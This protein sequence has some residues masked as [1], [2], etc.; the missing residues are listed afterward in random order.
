V[1]VK[2]L[3]V[4][5]IAAQPFIP[6]ARAQ[7]EPQFAAIAG[8]G[9]GLTSSDTAACRALLRLPSGDILIS[10]LFERAG[11][12][13]SANLAT[14]HPSTDTFDPISPSPNAS[15]RCL[16]RT[17]DG[18]IIAG[19]RFTAIGGVAANYIAAFDPATGLW[20]PLGSG[21]SG[22]VNAIAV[23]PSGDIV[24]GGEFF[25]A[26]GQTVRSVARYN[27]ASGAWAPLGTGVSGYVHSLL[28]LPS[29]DVLVGGDFTRVGSL[30]IAALA[31]YSFTT[32][33]W[34][35]MGAV[36][37]RSGQAQVLT[38]VALR[39]NQVLVGGW[40]SSI[41]GVPA[42]NVAVFD[43]ELGA[44]T[45]AGVGTD[46]IVFSAVEMQNGD[47]IVGGAFHAFGSDLVSC[48]A[49]YSPATQSW[50]TMGPGLNSSVRALAEGPDGGV[51]A[52]GDFSYSS[53]SRASRVA[54]YNPQTSEWAPL[55]G[56]PNDYVATVA[57][58]SGAVVIGGEFTH[59]MGLQ[60]NHVAKL[61]PLTGLW[62]SL[63]LGVNDTVNSVVRLP[64]GELA[65]GGYFTTAGPI[66]AA[67]IAI[68]DP[69]TDTWRA[70]G[71]GLTM[72]TPIQAPVGADDLALLSSG[73]ILAIG[74]FSLAGG[75]PCHGVAA[76]NP[77]TG[78]WRSVGATNPATPDPIIA[79]L[80]NG[81]FSLASGFGL[82]FV[83]YDPATDGWTQLPGSPRTILTLP[84]GKLIGAFNS[85]GP[86]QPALVAVFDFES[87][88][89]I[90]FGSGQEYTQQFAI[91]PDGLVLGAAPAPGTIRIYDPVTDAWRPLSPGP[92]SAIEALAAPSTSEIL[93]VGWFN[94][95]GAVGAGKVVS[96]QVSSPS[97]IQ[98]PASVTTRSGRSIQVSA[99]ASST[100]PT[101]YRWQKDGVNLA[102]GPLFSGSATPALTI[103]AQSP[104]QSGEY[105]L[106][107]S[108][109]CSVVATNPAS[110]TVLCAADVNGDLAVDSDDTISFFAIWNAADPAADL[111]DD[112]RIDGDDIVAF[113]EAF[114]RGC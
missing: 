36:T 19:G 81:S 92:D 47:V 38:I 93:V 102:D 28:A 64:N 46:H 18:L 110:I 27:R 48:V 25:A 24:A 12:V 42:R 17:Q 60:V 106:V 44:W 7:C 100:D 29:G 21:T 6:E 108:D 45:P 8:V 52:G 63:G 111:N 61:D 113:F 77:S 79:A 49:R 80:P 109:S 89:W 66:P 72:S 103:V 2:G 69:A 31:S 56:A 11:G 76:Y 90:P 1:W 88:R 97:I 34:S 58:N 4:S 91:R 16:A 98:H 9:E 87:S 22:F 20:S 71:S 23:L 85:I 30:N 83:S 35:S 95:I 99:Q 86:S 10:G 5:L 3:L 37:N 78:V 67:G 13:A 107:V 26:G 43:P 73:E 94:A 82:G 114:D 105:R 41:G 39:N 32:N 50:S 51:V 15:V 33:T 101:V 84:D 55:G 14:Y 65:I 59:L 74:P 40:L 70:L 53:R 112:T 54:Q 62:H 96:V 75:V 68:V 104:A 57:P